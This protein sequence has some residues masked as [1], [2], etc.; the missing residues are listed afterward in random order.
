MYLAHSNYLV[1]LVVPVGWLGAPWAPLWGVSPPMDRVAAMRE[2]EALGG[3]FPVSI[4]G[5]SEKGSWVD[6]RFGVI[7]LVY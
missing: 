7:R 5:L 1:I 4:K 6:F 3:S 2:Q